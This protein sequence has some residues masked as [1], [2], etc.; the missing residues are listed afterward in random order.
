MRA[1]TSLAVIFSA[2]S[3]ALPIATSPPP[4]DRVP[5]RAAAVP[6]REGRGGVQE[7]QEQQEATAER[8]EALAQALAD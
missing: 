1:R 2:L 8:E 6:E 3:L 4:H 7:A 5:A